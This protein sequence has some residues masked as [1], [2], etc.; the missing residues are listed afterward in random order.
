MNECY[1]KALE[2]ESLCLHVHNYLSS[3]IHTYIHTYIHTPGSVHRDLTP[4]LLPVCRSG[5]VPHRP[6]RAHLPGQLHRAPHHRRGGRGGEELP[7]EGP[8]HH[9]GHLGGIHAGQVRTPYCHCHCFPAIELTVPGLG[10]VRSME[11]ALERIFMIH[12]LL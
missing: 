4:S 5:V 11:D 2:R 7:E 12:K 9:R 3:H 1:S 6:G 8:H 10:W